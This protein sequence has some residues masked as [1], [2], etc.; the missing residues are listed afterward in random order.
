MRG[1]L[2]VSNS[3]STG[4]AIASELQLDARCLILDFSELNFMDSS[5]I[6]MLFSLARRLGE[7]RQELH[8]VAQ[9]DTAVARVLD[10][11]EFGRAAPVHPTLDAA[12]AAAGDH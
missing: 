10:I 5:A 3:A 2:D 6:S 12:L 8:V 11:V 7:R 9:Q 1:E 4:A